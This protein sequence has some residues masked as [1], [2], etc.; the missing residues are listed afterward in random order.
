MKVLGM[1]GRILLL[2]YIKQIEEIKKAPLERS[3]YKWEDIIVNL[4]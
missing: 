4:Y 1:D 3:R 2:I